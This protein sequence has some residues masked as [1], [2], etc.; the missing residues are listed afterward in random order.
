MSTLLVTLVLSFIIVL[1]ALCALA[2]GWLITGKSKIKGGTCGR[3][4]KKKEEVD[5]CGTDISCDLCSGM[6]EKKDDKLQ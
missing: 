5:G 4:P 3:V 1:F 6:E 2:I